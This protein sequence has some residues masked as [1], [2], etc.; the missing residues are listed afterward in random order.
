MKF[1]I[2]ISYFGSN[3]I[4]H[5]TFQPFVC[6]ICKLVV[7]KAHFETDLNLTKPVN[8]IMSCM[9]DQ[10]CNTIALVGH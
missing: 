10:I 7:L 6:P 3:S 1:Q 9:L 8:K 4:D 5:K 2:T